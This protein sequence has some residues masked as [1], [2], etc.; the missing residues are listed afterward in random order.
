MGDDEVGLEHLRALQAAHVDWISQTPF[1][2]MHRA[3]SPE[4]HLATSGV[5]WGETDEGL[6]TTARLARS[7]GIRTLLKPDIWLS[8]P[9]PGT[10]RADVAMK[11]QADWTRWWDGYRAFILHYARLAES[12][13]IEVL[14]LGTEL[15]AVVV[16]QEEEWRRLIADV[17]SVYG[18]KL[19]YSA[20]WYREFEEVPFWDALD[21][22]GIQAYFPLAAAPDGGLEELRSGWR[23]HVEAIERVQRAHGKPV[24]FTEIGYR[25]DADTAVE[26]W[27]WP[28]R[29][30]PPAGTRG[31]AAQADC[32]RSFFETFWGKEWFAGAYLWKWHPHRIAAGAAPKADFSPQGKP[33]LEVAAEWYARPAHASRGGPPR[34]SHPTAPR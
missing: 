16:G 9:E 8:R 27:R 18:G 20:N 33:A 31:L 22:I 14:S 11:S 13:G 19:V 7:L 2:W 34:V 26:P 1:G 6:I 4:V 29:P 30:I 3:D 12:A 15:R 5:L 21:F 17:R 32:Y 25:S 24:L 23:P 28:A 10:W